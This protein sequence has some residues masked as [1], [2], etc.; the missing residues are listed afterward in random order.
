M[1]E[2]II[3]AV[4]GSEFSD[5]AV[6]VAADLAEKFGSEVV[7]LHVAE[8]FASWTFA[9]EA[10]TPAESSGLTDGPVRFLKDRGLSA[11][12]EVQHALHGMV[13]RA[14][15]DAAEEEGADLIVMGSRGLGDLS[16]LLVGS[17]THKVLHI[18]RT[19]VLVVR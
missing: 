19:P 17:V 5:R 13:A 14:I 9:L 15:E 10:E 2:R 1:F 11:R 8:R 7:V 6:P 18:A 4:D 16:S 12:P 3:L